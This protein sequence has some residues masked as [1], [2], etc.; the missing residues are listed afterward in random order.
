MWGERSGRFECLLSWH[1]WLVSDSLSRDR[2]IR[3]DPKRLSTVSTRH[4]LAGKSKQL[5][6]IEAEQNS[7]V[8][9]CLFLLHRPAPGRVAAICSAMNTGMHTWDQCMFEH[10]VRSV[11]MCVYVQDIEFYESSSRLTKASP[12]NLYD[13]RELLADP[14]TRRQTRSET[15]W[16]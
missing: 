4:M 6:F 16:T 5:L 11:C 10:C 8:S 7:H 9:L 14:R 12:I 13:R 2:D 3:Y 15:E 1:R